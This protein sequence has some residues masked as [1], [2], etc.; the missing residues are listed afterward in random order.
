LIGPSIPAF[1]GALNLITTITTI[2]H[3]T[4]SWARRI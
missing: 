2:H 3:S 4:F 1:Y